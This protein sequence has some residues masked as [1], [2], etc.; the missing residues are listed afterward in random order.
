MQIMALMIHESPNR[1]GGSYIH[2][3][4]HSDGKDPENRMTQDSSRLPAGMVPM[5]GWLNQPLLN[6]QVPKSW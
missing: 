1:G 6:L 4:H 2:E 5:R 3:I